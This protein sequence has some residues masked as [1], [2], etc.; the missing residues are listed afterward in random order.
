MARIWPEKATVWVAPGVP[1][2][3]RWG[4]W[5]MEGVSVTL[6]PG[7]GVRLPAPIMRACSSESG[8]SGGGSAAWG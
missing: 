1:E 5:P 6:H 8:R 7:M 3:S 4:N 2:T